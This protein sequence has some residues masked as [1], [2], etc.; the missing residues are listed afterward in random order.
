[1][2]DRFTPDDILQSLN[3]ALDNDA[4]PLSLDESAPRLEL[5]GWLNGRGQLEVIGDDGEVL[6]GFSIFIEETVVEED[7]DGDD[8]ED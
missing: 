4:L 6:Q 5:A 3:G 8:G 1:M 2:S 7:E